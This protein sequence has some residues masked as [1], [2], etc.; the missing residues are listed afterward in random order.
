VN[1]DK[2]RVMQNNN[3]VEDSAAKGKNKASINE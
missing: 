2:Q 3:R 1:V